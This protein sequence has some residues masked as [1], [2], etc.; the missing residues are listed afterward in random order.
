MTAAVVAA[1]LLPL[2][3]LVVRAAFGGSLGWDLGANPVEE[4]T[5]ETGIWALR[6]LVATLAVT[7]LRRLT[8][9]SVIAPQR[10][11]LGLLAFFYATL[12]LA[13]YAGLDVGLDFEA[14]REDLADRTYITLGFATW[15]LLLPLALTSTR[16]AIRRLGQRWVGLHR[17]AYV[18]AIGAVAHYTWLV[19]KDVVPPLAYGAVVALLLAARLALASGRGTRGRESRTA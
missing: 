17:L 16:A 4:I 8:G 6:F 13:T 11:T 3:A 12:H 18:C 15:C 19:K 1:G 2:A 9:W 14:I 10:R 5:H 7:P